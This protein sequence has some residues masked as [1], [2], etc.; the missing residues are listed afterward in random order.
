MKVKIS[1]ELYS[2]IADNDYI[3]EVHF[4][5]T[6]AHYFNVNELK[7]DGVGTGKFY[8]WL[9]LEQVFSHEENHRKY[10]KMVNVA[11]PPAL[12]VQTLSRDEILKTYQL[13]E[14]L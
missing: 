13:Q 14:Q 6:G 1:H 3:K 4:T 9:K 5:K 10:Y 12:I 8:G 11:N 2:L 7:V